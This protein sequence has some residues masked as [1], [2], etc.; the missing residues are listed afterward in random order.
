MAELA[1]EQAQVSSVKLEAE[2]IPEISENYE[3]S[4]VLVTF[5]FFKNSQKIDRLDRAYAPEVTK[6][7]QQHGS[8]GSFPTSGNERPKGDLNVPGKKLTHAAPCMLFV[9]GTRQEPPVLSEPPVVSVSR[10]Q[11]ILNKHNIQLSSF[12][13]FS[14]EVHHSR[15]TYCNWPTY[16]R[17]YV[18]GDLTGGLDII[19]ELEASE[20]LDT[21]CS[22]APELEERH[23]VLTNKAS[24]MLSMKG[25]KQ[26][27]KCGFSTQILKTLNSSGVEY[28][29][30]DII[31]G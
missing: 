2:A 19:Q 31:G 6:T 10:Y 24:V 15:K 4:S 3:V 21:V 11:K 8:V 22:R 17:L 1:K 20:E 18:S 16:L 26:E 25:N 28:D 30:F 13:I 7:V 27:A 12:G 23:K 14:D 5:L 29:T 9:K